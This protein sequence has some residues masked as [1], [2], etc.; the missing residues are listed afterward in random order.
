MDY[1]RYFS[2]K[3]ALIFTL[4]SAFLS[5]LFC[6][7]IMISIQNTDDKV[8]E[9]LLKA[10]TERLIHGYQ[11]TGVLYAK[12]TLI[13]V[14]VLIENRDLIPQKW[15]KLPLGIHEDV[16]RNAHISKAEIQRDGQSLQVF[17]VHQPEISNVV[18]QNELSITLVLIFT[19]VFVTFIGSL[20]GMQLAKNIAKPVRELSQRIQNTDPDNPVFEPLQRS[21]EFGDI[22][23]AFSNTLLKISQVIEREK[24]Y[25]AFVSHEL[26]T[27]VA[28]IKS[29]LALSAACREEVETVTTKQLEL[30]ALERIS[31]ATQQMEQLILTFL[32]LGQSQRTEVQLKTIDLSQIILSFIEKYQ[33]QDPEKLIDI[34]QHIQ[35]NISMTNDRHIIELIITNIL[36]NAF[37]YCAGSI[38]FVLTDEQFSVH[39]DIDQLCLDNAEHFG[40]G[41]KIVEDLCG[42]LGW[43]FQS[44]E[45]ASN[46]Y[47]S[48]VQFKR[49]AKQIS[50]L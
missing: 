27:P 39:N 26:R 17:L 29:S 48:V 10:Q 20:L 31:I 45:T 14:E 23:L 18:D 21:D 2:R 37:S 4:F 44:G 42:A 6:L 32:F 46:Y 49:G 38:Q 7:L 36:R 24:Q 11:K 28:V 12:D 35:P 16:A 9:G 40:F 3:V 13:G 5:G 41:L 33:K 1:F 19:A 34:V 15:L 25:S 22:S 50:P 8:R 30:R 47:T 43:Q